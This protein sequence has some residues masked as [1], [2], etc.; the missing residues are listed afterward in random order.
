MLQQTRF[1]SPKR[2]VK[3]SKIPKDR[4]VSIWCGAVGHTGEGDWG[5]FAVEKRA[6]SFS[7]RIAKIKSENIF[8]PMTDLK[9]RGMK[10]RFFD[11]TST[12]WM[13]VYFPRAQV[14]RKR[15]KR[16]S[17]RK[18][19]PAYLDPGWSSAGSFETFNIQQFS[20]HFCKRKAEEKALR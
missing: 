8:L 3:L 2:D 16:G 11:R 19:N 10:S 4:W 15:T 12:Y 7:L 20:H 9:L 13:W 5:N 18:K 6:H 14:Q 1:N 17:A